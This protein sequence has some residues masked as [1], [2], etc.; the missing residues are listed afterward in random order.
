MILGQIREATQD[1]TRASDRVSI[2]C[3]RDAVSYL[4][5][6]M[7]CDHNTIRWYD[8]C[9]WIHLKTSPREWTTLSHQPALASLKTI[10]SFLPSWA[11]PRKGPT[12]DLCPRGTFCNDRR[13][14]AALLRIRDCRGWKH[15]AIH[16][17]VTYITTTRDGK[18]GKSNKGWIMPGVTEVRIRSCAGW[19]SGRGGGRTIMY[20]SERTKED[21]EG[22]ERGRERS[23]INVWR[24]AI[25]LRERD[26]EN[27]RNSEMNERKRRNET[28]KETYEFS[29]PPSP[30]ICIILI[31]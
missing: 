5:I 16:R 23:M 21:G 15:R 8:T 30:Y 14:V 7:I 1:T 20:L 12:K 22:C 10:I 3:G 31:L 13:Y 2:M 9:V 25:S 24:G 6:K 11:S 18:I 19:G 17:C 26:R 27:K 29:L 4:R 28:K